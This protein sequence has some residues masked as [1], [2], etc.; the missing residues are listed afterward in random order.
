MPHHILIVLHNL[1]RN[2]PPCMDLDMSPFA[3]LLLQFILRPL[4]YCYALHFTFSKYKLPEVYLCFPVNSQW[5][6]CYRKELI[7]WC[8]RVTQTIQI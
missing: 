4:N 5:S 6:I 3:V 7:F 8:Q 1:F 2:G